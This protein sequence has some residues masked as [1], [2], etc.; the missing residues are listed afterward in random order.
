MHVFIIQ[1]IQENKEMGEKKEMTTGKRSFIHFFAARTVSW[2]FEENR[3]AESMYA[4][5][6]NDYIFVCP[7]WSLC[8]LV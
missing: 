7:C 4:I 1:D 3:W 6:T 5:Y 8:T 2:Q